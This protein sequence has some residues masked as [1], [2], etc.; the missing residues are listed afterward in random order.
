MT[1]NGGPVGQ[2]MCRLLAVGPT[3]RQHVGD[4]PSQVQVPMTWYDMDGEVHSFELIMLM[5]HINTHLCHGDGTLCP[6]VT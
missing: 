3:C 2:K 4:F 1:K 5:R 6:S